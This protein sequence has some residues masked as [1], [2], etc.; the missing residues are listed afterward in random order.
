M[1]EK[2][3]RRNR[4]KVLR[5]YRRF[6]DYINKRKLIRLLVFALY[7]LGGLMTINQRKTNAVIKALCTRGLYGKFQKIFVDSSMPGVDLDNL[8]R[9]VADLE[10]DLD[11]FSR[12]IAEIEQDYKDRKYEQKDC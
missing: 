5:H 7:V 1:K 10:N 4:R 9:Q 8:Q 3:Y 2:M 6:C 11:I 12:D